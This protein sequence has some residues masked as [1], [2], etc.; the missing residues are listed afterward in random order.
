MAKV[1]KQQPFIIRLF[2][3][4]NPLRRPLILLLM[5]GLLKGFGALFDSPFLNKY[6]LY[7]VIGVGVVGLIIILWGHFHRDSTEG[8]GIKLN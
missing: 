3:R 8:V 7:I 5:L 4:P 6:G 1:P 2:L